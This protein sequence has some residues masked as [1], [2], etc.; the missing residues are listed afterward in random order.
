MH[1]RRNSVVVLCNVIAALAL[2]LTGCSST[3]PSRF[4][5]LTSQD[6]LVA[7]H[8]QSD[9]SIGVGPI[10]LPHY[11]D[12]PQIVTRTGQN[13]LRLAEFDRWAEPLTE[14]VSRVLTEDLCKLLET[15]QV[16][17]VPFRCS[18]RGE[19][20]KKRRQDE[21]KA[22][23]GRTSPSFPL[24]KKHPRFRKHRGQYV[25]AGKEPVEAVQTESCGSP[26]PP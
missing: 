2:V 23:T 17:I 26:N 18:P 14:N 8:L 22:K 12:R 5:V 16:S 11:L 1:W 20:A 24:V 7:G 25:R 19:G 9:V 4:F 10:V 13:E 6:R 15:E 21:E 3:S